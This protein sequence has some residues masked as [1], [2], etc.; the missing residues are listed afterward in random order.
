MVLVS[1]DLRK[2]LVYIIPKS[3]AKIKNRAELPPV[4]P[5]DFKFRFISG[6]C[7]DSWRAPQRKGISGGR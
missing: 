6:T 5:S 7:E 4:S 2:A 3:C 1:M